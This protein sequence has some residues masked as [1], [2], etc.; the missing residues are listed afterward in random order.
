MKLT[1]QSLPSRNPLPAEAPAHWVGNPP[2]CFQ[3]PWPSFKKNSLYSMFWTRFGKER[4]F[5]PVPES[6][7]ELV[8]VRA[9]DWGL[10]SPGLK[11]T[12]LGHAGFLVETSHGATGMSDGKTGKRGIRILFDTVFSER[13]SPVTWAGP[14]RYTPT[15]CTLDE[16]PD[17]DLVAISHDHYDHLDFET[18]KAVYAK[19]K[20]LGTPIHFLAGLNNKQ[21]F[22]NAGL[23]ITSDEVTECDWWDSLHVTL[24]GIGE[25]NIT[26]TPTQHFSGRGITD[27]GNTLWC[28]WAVEDTKAKKKLYFAGDTAYQAAGTPSPCPVFKQ[29]GQVFGGFDLALVPIG[30]FMPESFMGSVH[31][32][33]EQ[34]LKIHE[35]IG[36]RKTIGM[37]WGT[38]RGG[39]SGQYEDVR[40]PPR[41]WREASEKAG[42]WGTECG[43][44]DVGETVIV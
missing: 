32:S 20:K 16:L 25:I 21:W 8:Q 1:V 12:W 41:R 23:G 28:S 19:S 31:T 30:L 42:K 34:S 43:L 10:E 5:V 13:I 17:V 9:P 2:T 7:D 27:H 37:H 4:N 14:K 35:E 39:I 11:A 44:V 33:P 40:D 29:I 18:I 6:R 36:S 26:C 3:N 24:D 22:L 15:P 38:F